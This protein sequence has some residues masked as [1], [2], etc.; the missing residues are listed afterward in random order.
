MLPSFTP[1]ITSLVLGGL[2]K[3][4]T[5]RKPDITVGATGV[6]ILFL[7]GLVGLVGF[8]FVVIAGYRL[9]LA[10]FTPVEAA[11]ITGGVVL[12]LAAFLGFYGYRI[13][14]TGRKS[15]VAAMQPEQDE[16][17]KERIQKL[18]EDFSMPEL[19]ELVKSHPKSS[20]LVAVIAG[21]LAADAIR[22]N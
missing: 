3:A 11:G 16:G 13:I 7:A 19:E 4:A 10:S 12:L 6:G 18:L 9:M 22:S 20:V 2:T 21:L 1:I 14:K 15:V 8:V 5:A 17:L